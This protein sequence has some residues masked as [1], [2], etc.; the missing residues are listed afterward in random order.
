MPSASCSAAPVS[1][2]SD[3]MGRL[4]ERCSLARLSCARHSTTPPMDRANRLSAAENS[5][6]LIISGSS[7]RYLDQ[8]EVIH[9]HQTHA[10]AAA[11]QVADLLHIGAHAGIGIKSGFCNAICSCADIG[12]LL[13]RQRFIQ[14]RLIAD[15]GQFADPFCGP[16]D[17][18]SFP[19]IQTALRHTGP[20]T[21]RCSAP[22]W[23]YPWPDGPPENTARC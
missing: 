15:P 3:M 23:S 11:R 9:D 19:A 8:R 21:L 12:V 20:H 22:A 16:T 10:P 5:G 18:R 13:L 14:R 7:T 2:R 4:S 6:I 17:R 1:R